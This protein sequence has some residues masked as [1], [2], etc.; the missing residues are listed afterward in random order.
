MNWKR[1]GRT[2]SITIAA[3][4]FMTALL[5]VANEVFACEVCQFDGHTWYCCNEG[6]WE[7]CCIAWDEAHPNHYWFGCRRRSTGFCVA[8]GYDVVG[9]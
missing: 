5:G 2:L 1:S 3:L 8:Q 7:G 6:D 9:P 4:A